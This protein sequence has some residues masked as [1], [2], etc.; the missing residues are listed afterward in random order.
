MRFLLSLLGALSGSALCQSTNPLDLELQQRSAREG[1]ALVRTRNNW[2][3]DLLVGG[4]NTP[5]RN[6]KGNSLAW[7]SGNGDFV[8]WWILNSGKINYACPGSIAVTRRDGTLLWQVPGGFRGG[9]NPIRALGLSQDG[10]RVAL[11]AANVSGPSAP[12]LRSEL[13]LQWIDMS[14]MKIVRIGEAS[15]DQD[16][17]SISWAPNGNSF[18]FDRA[19]KIFVYDVASHGMSA[20]ADGSDP[21]WSPDGKLIAFRTSEGNAVSINPTTR[22]VKVLLASRK[23]LSPVQWSPDSQYVL[24]TER[25]SFREKLSYGDATITAVTRIYRL[26]D[27]SNVIVDRIYLESPDDRGR[28]WFW[29]TDYPGF[30]RGAGTELP[31]HC[32]ATTISDWKS[33][34]GTDVSDILRRWGS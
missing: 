20:I 2:I 25:A 11:Y 29:I 3:D 32:R 6:P 18:V 9:D 13:S 28:G 22:D 15:R 16:V 23:V 24:A 27:L 26:S 33:K 21:M 7:F 34:F 12:P 17:G 10:R 1:W 5:I 4:G 30:V 19:G 14:N 8:A 31:L